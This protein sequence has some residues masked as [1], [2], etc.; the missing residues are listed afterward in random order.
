MIWL[1]LSLLF[2]LRILC[3]GFGFVVVACGLFVDWCVVAG[4]LMVICDWLT[5]VCGI[6]R[7][8]VC[9]LWCL[10]FA[11]LLWLWFSDSIGF[12]WVDD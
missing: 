1:P 11:L 12:G 9:I 10:L 5:V 2:V 4:L 6:L 7:Y 8:N 3:F